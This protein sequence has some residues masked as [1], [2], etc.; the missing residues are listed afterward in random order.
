LKN[1]ILGLEKGKVRLVPYAPEWKLH[2]ESEKHALL[3]VLGSTV[4]DIQHVGSTSIPGMIAKP[5]IDIAIAVNDFEEAKICIPLV[6]SLG[7]EYK[8]EFGIPRRH[9]FVKGDPRLFHIH[10]SE[11]KSV[12]WQNTLLF[13][14]YLCHHP[15]A[16][17][18]YAQLKQQLAARYAQDR[19]AYLEGKTAYVE[20]VI[21]WAKAE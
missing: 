8:G 10:M 16:A 2:F 4:L 6:E 20:Q 19:E 5:I 15:E 11:I 1:E 3:R 13:R 17:K 7:Y 21:Q 18:A 12:E 9:Y 14:D